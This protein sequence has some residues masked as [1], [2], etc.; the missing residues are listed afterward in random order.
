MRAIVRNNFLSRPPIYTL[1]CNVA[2][3]LSHCRPRP[4]E[5]A[6]ILYFSSSLEAIIDTFRAS[7]II[8][9][10]SIVDFSKQISLCFYLLLY[11]SIHFFSNCDSGLGWQ[12]AQKAGRRERR[13]CIVMGGEGW[14]RQTRTK[15]PKWNVYC[16]ASF[17]VLSSFIFSS[18][19]APMS[20]VM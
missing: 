2:I 15:R 16:I 19:T 14:A 13:F 11:P 12:F 17:N 4:A 9:T 7:Y 6:E 20:V 3:N 10:Y 1:Q 5:M 8:S 18:G